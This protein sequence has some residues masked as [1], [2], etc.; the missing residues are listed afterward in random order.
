MSKLKDK[1]SNVM[2]Q[3]S[4]IETLL[5]RYPVL[6]TS[7]PL[8]TDVSINTSVGFMLSLL[9][10]FG[11]TQT[12]LINWLCKLLAG[13]DKKD[14]GILN[15]IEQAVKAILM[16]NIK[17][18]Y[19]CHV[20]PIL[21][22]DLMKS[23][24]SA[25]VDTTPYAIEINLDE[26]DMF[27]LLNNCP[28]N[29]EGSI[30][31]FDAFESG[32]NANDVWKSTDFNAFLWYVINKGN[33]GS[34]TSI[35]QNTWDNRLKASKIYNDNQDLKDAFFNQNASGNESMDVVVTGDTEPNYVEKKQYII[36]EYAESGSKG[37]NN[38]LKVA[39]NSDRYKNT[40]VFRNK[41]GEII[42]Q[43]NKTVF[44]F[45]YDYIYSLKLFD[46]KTLVANITNSLLGLSSS[47]SINFSSQIKIMRRKVE[48]IVRNIIKADDTEND[49][50]YYT[51]SNEQYEQMLNDAFKNYNTDYNQTSETLSDEVDR[52]LSSINN[53]NSDATKVVNKETVIGKTFEQI[54]AITSEEQGIT[55]ENEFSFNIDFISKFI[56]QTVVEIAL[57][58]LS[59][60]VAVL[61]IINSVIMGGK[62]DDVTAWVDFIKNWENIIVSIVRQVKD[63][64]LQELYNYLMQQLQPILQLFISKLA[65]ETVKDYKDLINNL[66]LNCIP[67]INLNLGGTNTVIDNVNYADI[68]PTQ[69][70]PSTNC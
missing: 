66:I 35:N 16:L 17:S 15:S 3:L 13:D 48:D 12:D 59:P 64:I 27:G 26:I 47:M 70:K 4:A 69:T 52:I 43:M 42:Y 58:I 46:S 65:I 18:L 31:Y 62:V 7:D 6:S 2:G 40:R 44:E 51:F 63:L 32:Y 53:I 41:D 68:I 25:T 10:L 54:M 22:D 24:S 67:M 20:D 5:E 49:D 8:L 11:I 56:E 60:K 1:Q 34:E 19:T 45:N 30:F 21:P 55:M 14:S 61:Y 50:C 29:E 39:I 37:Y 33:T 28:V 36:C 23:P 38:I 57:Q 9:S